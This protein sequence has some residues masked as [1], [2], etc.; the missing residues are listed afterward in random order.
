M[1]KAGK[2]RRIVR[3]GV[4]W[5]V[6]PVP[7]GEVVEVTGS[8]LTEWSMEEDHGCPV[9]LG[10]YRVGTEPTG[11]LDLRCLQAHARP[12]AAETTSEVWG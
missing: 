7:L 11:Q 1:I 9:P 6:H 4:R 5:R 12:P 2:I 3:T 8:L 10:E